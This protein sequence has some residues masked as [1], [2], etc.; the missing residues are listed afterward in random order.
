MENFSQNFIKRLSC[1]KPR[2]ARVLILYNPS[3]P[4]R[5]EAE[6]QGGQAGTENIHPCPRRPHPPPEITRN[7]R[8]GG[9]CSTLAD[10]LASASCLHEQEVGESAAALLCNVALRSERVEELEKQLLAGALA[11]QSVS[12]V[13]KAVSRS[14]R[15]GQDAGWCVHHLLPA[16][17]LLHNVQ[18]VLHGLLEARLVPRGPCRA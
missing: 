5:A 1:V 6:R 11:G 14:L 12:V 4:S 10:G 16:R 8:W 17:V 18:A 2:D 15:G 7:T 3:R 13:A 9:C